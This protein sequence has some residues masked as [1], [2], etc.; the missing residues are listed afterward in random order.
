MQ[1]ELRV[2]A[3]LERISG[4]FAG[5]EEA[6]EMIAEEIEAADPGE[7]SL[8]SAGGAESLYEVTE[9]EVQNAEAAR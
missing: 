7:L 8:M 6:Q 1:V 3:T 9:W 4:P 5:K 2:T